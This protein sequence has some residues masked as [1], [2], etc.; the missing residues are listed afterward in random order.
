MVMTVKSTAV[1][2]KKEEK[3]AWEKFQREH[4]DWNASI[5]LVSVSFEKTEVLLREEDIHVRH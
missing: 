3:E 4:P 1:F 5:G 2:D